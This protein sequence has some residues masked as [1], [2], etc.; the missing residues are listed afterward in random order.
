M[1]VLVK[2]ITCGEPFDPNEADSEDYCSVSCIPCVICG[3][4][5]NGIGCL[6]DDEYRRDE[7]ESDYFRFNI[8]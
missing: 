7:D 8:S 1:I 4:T 3:V 6:C 5:P 2:C